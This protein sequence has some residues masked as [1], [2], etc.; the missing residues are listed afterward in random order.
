[1]SDEKKLLPEECIKDSRVGDGF[2]IL[3]AES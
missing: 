1:M 2:K 3:E